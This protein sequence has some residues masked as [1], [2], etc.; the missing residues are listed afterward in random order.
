M[1][2]KFYTLPDTT[3][4][5]AWDLRSALTAADEITPLADS[6]AS[7]RESVTS[8]QQSGRINAA[9][10]HTLESSTEPSPHNEQPGESLVAIAKRRLQKPASSTNTDALPAEAPPEASSQFTLTARNQT[11]ATMLPVKLRNG[12]AT[13]SLSTAVP[14]TA[15]GSQEQIRA[16][17]QHQPNAGFGQLFTRLRKLRSQVTEIR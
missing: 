8:F 9:A 5:I 11:P 6:V 2:D 16:E 13:A 15:S 12:S 17:G 4:T 3:R 1:T 7:L 10:S 14:Q